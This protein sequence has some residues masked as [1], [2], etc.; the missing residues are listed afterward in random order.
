MST[1]TPEST[2]ADAAPSPS[3]EPVAQ[4]AG[5][6]PV[7]RD[8]A[9]LGM[10]LLLGQEF[11]FFAGLL[12]AYAVFRAWYP[13][14]FSWAAQQLNRV[15]YC[16]GAFALLGGSLS[17]TLAVR[18]ARAGDRRDTGVWLS[19]AI[20]CGVA[21]LALLGAEYGHTIQAGFLP[22]SH[23][24]PAPEHL[25]AGT[26]QLRVPA[27]GGTFFGLYLVIT[28]L[29]AV[30]VLFGLG[31][32]GWAFV[33]N[34]RGAVTVEDGT[35]VEL[36]AFYAHVLALVGT[37][38]ALAILRAHPV[39][40]S[41][42]LAG[43]LLVLQLG[44]VVAFLVHARAESRRDALLL[45]AACAFAGAFLAS[46]LADTTHRG[47]VDRLQGTQLN[48]ATGERAPGGMP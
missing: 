42:A 15:L 40:P 13:Q 47:Q 36:A 31:L 33:R 22:G 26:E 19:V 35:S 38:A 44:A 21:F 30:H 27:H 29:L 23:F 32:L 34:R 20:A 37:V 9:H 11:V 4:D 18:A 6:E 24:R 45:V 5:A 46:T 41:L 2:P 17:A 14:D 25:A 43:V 39:L 1:A 3:S 10:W 48:D 7:R 28:G 8:T 12:V 16:S